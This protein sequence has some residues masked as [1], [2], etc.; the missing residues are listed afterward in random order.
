M[1]DYRYTQWLR[2]HWDIAAVEMESGAIAKVC[3]V[4]EVPF[5]QIRSISDV[6]GNKNPNEFYEF[7]A[8]AEKNSA[9]LL[10]LVMQS[11]KLPR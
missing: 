2:E 7:K 5:M 1:D 8:V 6:I 3:W 10:N 4:N 9:R 11:G